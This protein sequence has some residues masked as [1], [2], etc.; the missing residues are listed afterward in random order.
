MT[1]LHLKILALILCAL[2]VA[3]VWYKVSVI[4]LPLQPDAETQTWTV[5]ARV[6]YQAE[7]GPTQVRLFL[8]GTQPKFSVLGEAF[9]S[10]SFGLAR[11]SEG[12]NRIALWTARRASGEQ[13]LYYR[14]R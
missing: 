5:E 14:I 2:G 8:P 10:G 13:T 7:G 4:G 1:N 3:G 6:S 9:V 11:E 12:N